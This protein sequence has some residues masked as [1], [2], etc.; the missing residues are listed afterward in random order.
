[1]RCMRLVQCH[2]GD[3]RCQCKPASQ[4]SR[5]L[6]RQQLLYTYSTVINNTFVLA[7]TLRRRRTKPI[8]VFFPILPPSGRSEQG[9]PNKTL[10]LPNPHS[11]LHRW[12]LITDTHMACNS[13]TC[14]ALLDI[15]WSPSSLMYHRHILNAWRFG[16]QQNNE[17]SCETLRNNCSMFWR[18]SLY[19][20]Y[21]LTRHFNRLR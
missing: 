10:R 8:I 7:V 1:M 21:F 17:L 13:I 12:L 9:Q 4:T 19:S 11:L 14:P 3:L 15:L 18:A 20:C 2:A 5:S 16:H 6:R